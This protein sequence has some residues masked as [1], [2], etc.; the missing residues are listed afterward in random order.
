MALI[1]KSVM[2]EYPAAK[3]LALVND[4]ARYPEF[5]PWCTGAEMVRENADTLRASL[6][7]GYKG[8][9]QKFSTRNRT[10]TPEGNTPGTITMALVDGPF[11]VL[12]GRWSFKPLGE[13]ACKIE[14]RLH[15]EFSSKLLEKVVGPAFG[16][17][18][19]SFVEAFVHRAGTLYGKN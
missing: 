9:N 4:I 14:F 16:R 19:N 1:E 11:R 7:I 10:Q 18:A 17:I 13:E 12:D 2:V 3:M 5:L 6:K 15:Y 8:I